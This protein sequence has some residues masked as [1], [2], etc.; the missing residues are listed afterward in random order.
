[1]WL[2]TQMAHK[3]HKRLWCRKETLESPL[4]SPPW[5]RGSAYLCRLAAYNLDFCVKVHLTSA[6]S[7]FTTLLVS[8][9]LFC[10]EIFVLFWILV[11]GIEFFLIN[12]IFFWFFSG[13]M[14]SC[15]L[16]GVQ[17]WDHPSFLQYLLR[18]CIWGIHKIYCLHQ[19]GLFH[20]LCMKGEHT[21]VHM[22]LWK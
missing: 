17:S 6:S 8:T 4:C 14:S 19:L 20:Q 18:T 3:S 1:M 9:W 15:I 16:K 11:S 10:I 2:G 5:S 7:C 22:L 13:W 12:F 21:Y